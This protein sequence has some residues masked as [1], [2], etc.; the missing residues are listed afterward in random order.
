M[1]ADDAK[2][3]SDPLGQLP[4]SNM[5]ANHGS[6]TVTS[7]SGVAGVYDLNLLAACVVCGLRISNTVRFSPWCLQ[8]KTLPLTISY[9]GL[10]ELGVPQIPVVR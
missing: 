6:E 9:G 8:G 3:V 1:V 5:K 10:R 7:S 4:L 2:V